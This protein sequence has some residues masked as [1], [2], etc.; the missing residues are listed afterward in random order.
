VYLQGVA[1]CCRVLQCLALCCNVWI[2]AIGDFYIAV[3][4]RPQ[5]CICSVSQCVVVWCSVLQHDAECC[6]VLQLAGRRCV[7]AGCCRVLQGVAGCCRVWQGVAGC[8]SVLQCVAV[9]CSVL[10]CVA[11]CEKSRRLVTVIFLSVVGRTCAIYSCV[12]TRHIC[13]EYISLH[14]CIGNIWK[15]L[16]CVLQCVA[17]RVA[18]CCT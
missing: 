15:V 13:I 5:V 14:L 2:E 8:C 16:H 12:C 17:M 3:V 18:L 10:Q 7:V 9:C 4:G 1:E 11:V 6:N